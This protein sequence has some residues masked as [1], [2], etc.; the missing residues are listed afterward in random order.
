MG[1]EKT[2]QNRKKY[3][4]SVHPNAKV[5]R[6]GKVQTA[7]AA[8]SKALEKAKGG[9]LHRAE[10]QKMEKAFHKSVRRAA[11]NPKHYA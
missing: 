1:D 9:N 4:S 8:K 7:S 2:Y 6:N 5:L 11:E 3:G 10:S